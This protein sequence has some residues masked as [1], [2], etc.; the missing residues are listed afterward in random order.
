M[1]MLQMVAQYLKLYTGYFLTHHSQINTQ[2][3]G[4]RNEIQIHKPEHGNCYLKIG[5]S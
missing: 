1:A 4:Y 5:G 3:Q 2:D